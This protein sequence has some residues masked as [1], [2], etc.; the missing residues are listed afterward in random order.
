MTGCETFEQAIELAKKGDST[1]V[2]KLVKDIYGGDYKRFGLSGETI[3]CSFGHMISKEKR[4]NAKPED[5]AQATLITITNNI[6][7]IAMLCAI[8]EKID[9]VIFVGNFLRINPLSM[10]LLSNAMNY[11]SNGTRRA[12]FL[13]H[14]GQLCSLGALIQGHT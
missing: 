10:K 11:W 2:D 8:N 6:A 13:E 1:K 9:K 3:A 7:S 14:E 12:L 4:E 5:L